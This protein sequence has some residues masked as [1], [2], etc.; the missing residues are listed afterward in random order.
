M[1]HA[2]E[3]SDWSAV[4]MGLLLQAAVMLV[5]DLFAEH[6]AHVYARWLLALSTSAYT[7]P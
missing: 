3:Q 1:V 5:F 2:H 7:R 6:R 4:G